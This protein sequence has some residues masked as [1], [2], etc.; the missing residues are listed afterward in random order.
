M[1]PSKKMM[2]GQEG[3]RAQTSALTVCM[4]GG[5]GEMGQSSFPH[6]VKYNVQYMGLASY[7]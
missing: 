7:N 5:G 4:C 6:T 1:G 2:E 3:E